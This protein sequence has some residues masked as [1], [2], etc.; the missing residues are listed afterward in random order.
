MSRHEL[1]AADYLQ[2]ILEA[3]DRAVGYVSGADTLADF[4]L[5]G[6]AHSVEAD[7]YHAQ[8][9]DP[10]LLRGG[11]RRGVE[12]SQERPADARNAD[13]A[14][15]AVGPGEVTWTRTT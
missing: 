1:R 2:H 9:G 12:H 15:A 8:P 4:E 10:R 7:A 3:I 5:N 6:M 14:S 11:R 13:S